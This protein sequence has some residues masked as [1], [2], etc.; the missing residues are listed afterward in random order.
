[1]SFLWQYK[2]VMKKVTGK[3]NAYSFWYIL[4][5]TWYNILNMKLIVFIT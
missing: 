1:M 2:M 3:L 5:S 4:S